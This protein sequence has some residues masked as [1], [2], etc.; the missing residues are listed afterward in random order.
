M[1]DEVWQMHFNIKERQLYID[2]LYTWDQ[3][4]RIEDRKQ[5]IYPTTELSF[6]WK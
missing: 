2:V 1:R 5:G 3:L 4:I 6:V